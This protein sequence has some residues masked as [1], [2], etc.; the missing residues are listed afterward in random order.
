MVFISLTIRIYLM[1]D[2]SYLFTADKQDIFDIIVL[3]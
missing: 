3:N 2:A 1:F